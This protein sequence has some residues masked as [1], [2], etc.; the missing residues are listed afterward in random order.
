MYMWLLQNMLRITDPEK[1]SRQHLS[2]FFIDKIHI[3]PTDSLIHHDSFQNHWADCNENWH[4]AS[5]QV[6]DAKGRILKN[7]LC[8]WSLPLE[9]VFVKLYSSFSKTIARI[10]KKFRT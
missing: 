3:P 9:H 10:T 2:N 6:I 8:S 5:T 1:V 4:K 7:E